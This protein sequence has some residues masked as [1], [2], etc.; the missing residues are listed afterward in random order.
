M[1]HFLDNGIF[2]KIDVGDLIYLQWELPNK[3]YL[4]VKYLIVG[5]YDIEFRFYPAYEIKANIFCRFYIPKLSNLKL[6]EFQIF[7]A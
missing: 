4:V 1:E 7:K 2:V 5:E 3:Q 6:S